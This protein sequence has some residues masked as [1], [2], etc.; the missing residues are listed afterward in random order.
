MRG[1]AGLGHGGRQ[2]DVAIGGPHSGVR[3][4]QLERLGGRRLV[5]NRPLAHRRA[6]LVQAL[7]QAAAARKYVHRCQRQALSARPIAQGMR[8]LLQSTQ[9]PSNKLVE[10]RL[11]RLKLEGLA[12]Y[13]QQSHIPSMCTSN[14]RQAARPYDSNILFCHLTY[15]IRMP[16]SHSS[17][18]AG[19][20]TAGALLAAAPLPLPLSAAGGARSSAG[21]SPNSPVLREYDLVHANVLSPAVA[22]TQYK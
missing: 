18:T 6:R 21:G 7:A 8:G 22:P 4:V 2:D 5:L 11:Q 15:V 17:S 12:T 19:A 13:R 1:Q 16:G 10:Q 9:P 14:K 3:V 20:S